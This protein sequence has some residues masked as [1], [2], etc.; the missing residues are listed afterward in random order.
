MNKIRPE[1]FSLAVEMSVDGIVI[2]DRDGNILY[3]N[4]A[5]LKLFGGSDKVELIG[6]NVLEFIVDSEKP[7]AIERT[8]NS[9]KTGQ[10]WKDQFTTISK[11]GTKIF[12][13]VTATPIKN[14]E[15]AS[16]A[17]IDI[18]RDVTDRVQTEEKLK[19]AHHKLEVANEKLLVVSGLVRHDIANNLNLL[20]LER[21]LAKKNGD[22]EGLLSA[23]QITC[24]HIKRIIELSRDY[25]LLGKEALGYLNVGSVFD[26]VVTLFPD[27]KLHVINDCRR[28]EV[29]A[30]SLLKELFYNLFENTLKY[31]QTATQIRLSHTVDSENLKLT[32]EDN[33]IGIPAEIRPK[34]FTKGA[35]RGSGLGLYLIK[36]TTEVYGW[37]IQETGTEGKNAK[38]TITIPQ[39]NYRQ[40]E[41]FV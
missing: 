31:G 24:A 21:Y 5:T 16:I 37:N 3:V 27:A 29:L 4:D 20:N 19:E 39:A 32:Y 1:L 41:A 15:G 7:R 14:A 18:V 36:K 13:E 11:N 10:G 23:T 38:F 2:G 40:Q 9:W 26:E 8:L 6:R 34:L 33:G 35:G 12:I 28:L 22:L 17:F 25:E 30:D